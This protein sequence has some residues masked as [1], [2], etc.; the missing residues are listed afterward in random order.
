MNAHRFSPLI[1]TGMPRSGLSWVVS[2]IGKDRQVWD[3]K[4]LSLQRR[5]IETC[6][7]ASDQGYHEWGWMEGEQ[8]DRGAWAQF[9]PEARQILLQRSQTNYWGWAD[10]RT[11]LLLDF[12]ESLLPTARYILIYRFPWDVA[13]SIQRQGVDIFLRQPEYAFRMW[14]FYNRRLLDFYRRHSE[15]CVLLSA[16]ALSKSPRQLSALL[17]SKLGTR[18]GEGDG[19]ILFDLARFKTVEGDDPLIDLLGAASPEVITLLK[20]MDVSAD[21]SSSSLWRAAPPRARLLR[22][23]RSAND[24]VRV[25]IVIPSYDE[26][27]L[28]LEAV[29]SVERCAPRQSELIVVDDG[30]EDQHTLDVLQVLRAGGYFVQ[31]E[32]HGGHVAALNTAVSLARGEYILPLAHD[33]ILCPGFIEAAVDVLNKESSVGVVYGNR[34]DFGLRSVV[35]DVPAFDLNTLLIANHFDAFAL[36]RRK[37]WVECGG[38]DAAMLMEDW[39]FW[40][41]AASHGWRFHKLDRVGCHYRVRP[42]SLFAQRA[43]PEVLKHQIMHVARKHSQLYLTDERWITCLSEMWFRYVSYDGLAAERDTAEHSVRELSAQLETIYRSKH[44]RIMGKYWMFHAWVRKIFNRFKLSMFG[45]R[46]FFA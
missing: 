31:R 37:V 41:N 40:V 12:W 13:D 44:W 43:S 3:E 7:D 15:R 38:Y 2:G 24:A 32:S 6:C 11:T 18:V 4:I 26:G 17:E 22:P 39:E 30:S 21:I 14:L 45:L 33:N 5:M 28:L 20:E 1:V 23:D 36:F 8:L 16:N 29:A 10:P 19:G 25:S 27:Q 42:N 35:V 34:R 9:I 46:R